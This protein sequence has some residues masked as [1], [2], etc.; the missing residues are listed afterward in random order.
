MLLL[1][2]KFSKVWPPFSL[3]ILDALFG[4]PTPFVFPDQKY[5]SFSL[6][7]FLIVFSSGKLFSFILMPKPSS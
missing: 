6:M 5:D 4:P 1:S 2:S 3:A 7:A